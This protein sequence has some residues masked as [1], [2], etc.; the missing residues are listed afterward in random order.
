MEPATVGVMVKVCVVLEFEKVST[1]AERPVLPEPDGVRVI[2]P[3]YGLLGVTEKLEEVLPALPEE[4]PLKV[5]AVAAQALVV[6]VAS[7][8]VPVPPVFTAKAST[9]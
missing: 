1:V 2:V 5:Y 3:V 8:E 4:G 6:N 7:D 9:W